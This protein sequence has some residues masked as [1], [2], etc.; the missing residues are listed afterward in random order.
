MNTVKIVFLATPNFAIPT[1]GAVLNNS[2]YQISGIITQP[3]KPSGRGLK[4]I[5]SPVKI[6]A[7]NNDIPCFQPTSLNSLSIDSNKTAASKNAAMESLCHFL[8]ANKHSLFVVIAFGQI[9]PNSLLQFSNYPVLNI[10][11]S[12]LPRWR[13]AAPIQHALFAGDEVTGVTIM[14][15]D[16][17]L[18]TGPVFASETERIRSTDD[19][20]SL[21]DRLA[22]LGCRLLLNVI[23]EVL[24]KKIKSVSQKTDG[25]TYATKWDK[26]D[27]VINWLDDLSITERRIRTCSPNLGARTKYKDQMIKIFAAHITNNAAY[28]EYP[29]GTIVEVNKSELV[30]AA[31]NSNYLSI[32]VLQFPGKSKAPIKEILRGYN[33]KVGEKFE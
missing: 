16:K 7:Q 26:S 15:I 10:H 5:P 6:F 23:P 31:P 32:D 19:F 29:V 33:F 2:P 27:C 24:S 13:G 9:I 11:P 17:G 21:H 20:G 1:L 8:N 3:D 22:E 4:L 14:G 12:L 30:V 28:P 18:D 25:V